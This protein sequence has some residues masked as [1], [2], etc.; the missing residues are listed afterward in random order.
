MS[1]QLLLAGLFPPLGEQKWHPSLAWQPIPVNS[2]PS[3]YEDV[4]NGKIIFIVRN[5]KFIFYS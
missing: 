2:K 3:K 5:L 1:A 4:R